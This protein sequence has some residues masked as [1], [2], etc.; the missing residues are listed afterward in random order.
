VYNP[1]SQIVTRTRLNDVYTSNSAENISR[2]YAR[3]GLMGAR[4]HVMMIVY[5][6]EQRAFWWEDYRR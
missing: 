6:V 4:N 1:A 2:D 3:N 5:N